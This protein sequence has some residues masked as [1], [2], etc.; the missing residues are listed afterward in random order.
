MSRIGAQT[1]TIPNQVTVEKQGQLILVK[2][3]KGSL[4]VNVP[5]RLGIE[6]ANGVVSIT[7]KTN[8]T[9]VKSLH[10]LTRTLVNNAILGSVQG[11]EKTV[12]LIGVGYRAAGGGQQVTLTVGFSHPVV[13]Q[14]PA[15]ITFTIK[16]NT[17]I[18]IAGI[19]KKL[20]GETAAQMRAVRPPEPYKGKGIR[21]L[22]E[23]VR[24]K[25][26]KAVKAAA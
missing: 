4:T 21:Y 11:W 16:D 22:G 19:D 2:G 17:K 6:I 25:A 23:V 7:N 20:V 24:K 14:A 5:A 12:E 1:I 3:P 8:D 13:V 26:G 18:S 9:F 15:G 10:G